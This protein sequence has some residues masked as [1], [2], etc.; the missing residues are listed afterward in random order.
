MLTALGIKNYALIEDISLDLTENFSIITG[1]TGAGK[2]IILGALSLLLGKR[3]DLNAIRDSEKKCVIEGHFLIAEYG[4]KSLFESN[5]LDY[6]DETIIRREILPSGKSRAFVNDSPVKLSNL[7]TV[8]N[9]LIDIHS[10]HETLSVGSTNYQ[11]RILD[12]VAQNA[13]ISKEYQA[14][15]KKFQV[16]KQEFETLKIQQ[17][18]AD[19]AYDYNL[20]LLTE[21]EEAKLKPGIQEDWESTQNK[22]SHV[23]E[24]QERIG[25]SVNL[26]EDESIGIITQLREANQNFQKV[27]QL[28]SSFKDLSE[29][30]SSVLIEM[31]DISQETQNEFEEL[32]VNPVLLEDIN[33]KLENLYNLQKKHHV[34]NIENLIEIQS[35]LEEKVSLK[36][37]AEAEL[38]KF[39]KAISEQKSKLESIAKELYK[40]RKNTTKIIK[41]SVENM[42]ADLGIEDAQLKIESEFT[43]EFAARGADHFQWLFS[44]NKGNALQDIKKVASGGELSRITLA[45]KSL[46][47]QYDNLP[48][49][50]FD[51]IDTGVSGD[52]ANKMGLIMQDMAK[53][54]Q[55]ISI[56]HLP[57]IA[58]K[59]EKHFK[60]FK[61]T[62]NQ[63]TQSNIKVLSKEER[64]QELAEMLGGDKTS[65]SAMAHAASLL[66]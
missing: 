48:T 17:Q 39:E 44:A 25:T 16:L 56:T 61:T 33:S 23:E 21:L 62:V 66:K 10:Q 59:G 9:H 28:D 11:Y 12:I 5:D 54:M 22:L 57:Q 34:D 4:L 63:K 42:L 43:G 27:F 35:E 15:F 7:S 36:Q 6:E 47:A 49:I 19:E 51:E 65:D 52:V 1:E 24:L 58:A 3:A 41:T 26:F 40:S 13:D 20:F 18:K 31:E 32:E 38:K 53:S 37:N 60:V 46:L 45:I 55:V 50:V 29:R 2:S 64:L 14:N 8:G 30:I